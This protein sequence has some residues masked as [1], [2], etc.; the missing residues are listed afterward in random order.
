MS[1]D[2]KLLEHLVSVFGEQQAHFVQKRI[3][4]MI[5]EF[6]KETL[7]GN[8]DDQSVA[9]SEKDVILITYGDFVK[10][11]GQTP[12]H[13]LAEFLD[14][15]LK[16]QVSI[17][18]ILPFFPY[19]SDDGFSVINYRAVNPALGSWDDVSFLASNY[20]L[21]FDAVV[22]HISSK[23]EWFTGFI[24]GD[25]RYQDYFITDADNWDLS[26]VV[27]PRTSNLLTT[28]ETSVGPQKV[29]TT[30]SADQIDLNFANPTVFLEIINLLLFYVRKGASVIR[31]DA[32]AYLWKESGTT[33]IHLPQTHR[34][35]KVMRMVLE[36]VDPY[37]ILITETNVPHIENIS[38]F[39][40]INP[41][42]G[43]GDEAHMVYQFSLAPLVLHTLITG[44]TDRINQWVEN[45]EPTGIFMN[46]IASHDGIGMMPAIGL[47]SDDDIQ[48]IIDQVKAHQ[49]L[50]SYKSN[51]DGS[52]TVYELNTTLYDALNN[53]NKLNPPM[54]IARFIASQI[55]MLSLA[56][57][58][59][60]YFHSLLGSRNAHDFY[61]E[62]GR[63]RSI[64]RKGFQYN[65]LVGTLSNPE[66]VHS[67]I[68]KQYVR[69]LDIRTSEPAFHPEGPQKVL[70]V[71]GEV[72]ALERH[73]PDEDSKVLVIV[74]VTEDPFT[75]NV[76]LS[77]T[78]LQNHTRFMDLISG[79][80][81]FG[82]ENRLEIALNPYQALWLKV[83]D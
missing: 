37:M 34:L 36:M 35:I 53:P 73:S 74:N 66:N 76:D 14:S 31:L 68:F 13:T 33:C 65:S 70:R 19:S 46:F 58:P 6:Q 82:K 67:Q 16:K 69:L 83:I 1:T 47:I 72:F 9:I 50:V 42:T 39:G 32:I 75:T 63:E 45:L 40:N 77:N 2:N 38:Y 26:N 25:D 52:K 78:D 8:A 5:A 80:E 7:P 79:K 64:N 57:V 4:E 15:Y 41:E 23:S 59:G 43:V 20:R 48:R 11:N 24:N 27:R 18:H 71:A 55:I 10:Q 62:T 17:V 30:F 12:L 29:W 44:N 51:P 56:G 61:Q 81:I 22:N 21:M 54:D 49:G 3:M 60:I 28:V